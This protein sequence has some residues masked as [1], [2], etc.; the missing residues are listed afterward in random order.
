MLVTGSLGGD[1]KKNILARDIGIRQGEVLNGLDEN[2][3]YS[4]IPT[5]RRPG[6]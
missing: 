5:T 1:E 6:L 2:I 4:V 3:S